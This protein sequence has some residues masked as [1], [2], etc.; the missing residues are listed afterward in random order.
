MS[1]TIG[2]SLGCGTPVRYNL[3]QGEDT[4]GNATTYAVSECPYVPPVE[5]GYYEL[6]FYH[7][8]SVGYDTAPVTMLF[9]GVVR[10][11]ELGTIEIVGHILCTRAGYEYR[12]WVGP[13]ENSGSYHIV[14]TTTQEATWEPVSWIYRP[15]DGSYVHAILG[16]DLGGATWLRRLWSFGDGGWRFPIVFD[17][18]QT[19]YADMDGTITRTETQ[20]LCTGN[21]YRYGASTAWD[22]WGSVTPGEHPDDWVFSDYSGVVQVST[23][24]YSTVAALPDSAT[25]GILARWYSG[26]PYPGGADVTRICSVGP[27]YRPAHDPILRYGIDPLGAA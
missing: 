2:Y 4:T 5:T 17:G 16:A 6:P 1:N 21:S 11:W 22:W 7:T 25:V 23:P 14:G 10:V 26:S 18:F 19:S 13:S 15:E 27:F 12:V 9:R 20:V 8:L 3:T 24:T